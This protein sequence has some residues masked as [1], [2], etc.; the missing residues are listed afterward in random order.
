MGR[1][2]ERW[3]GTAGG[4]AAALLLG[5]GAVM[6]GE[7]DFSAEVSLEPRLFFEQPRYEGQLTDLQLSGVFEAEIEWESE[8]RAWEAILIPW[9]RLDAEDDDRSHV[10]LREG[11]LRWIGDAWEVRAGLGKVFWGVTE[12]RHL[13]DIIN[14][15]DAV[16]DIDEEDKLGQPMVE[17]TTIRNWGTLRAWVL[18]GFRE[19]T[20]PGERG[21]LR[22][23]FTVDKDQAQYESADEERR[24]DGALRYS[25]VFGD[26]D[27]G[28]S[29]FHGT[30]R[31][32]RLGFNPTKQQ[33]FPIYDVI[34][35][36]G[37]DVQYTTGPWLWKFEGIV[38]EGQGETFGAVTGGFEYTF[39]GITETG[40]DLGVLLE[41]HHDGRDPAE[42]PITPFDED[43]FIGARLALN[44]V[45]DTSILVGGIVDAEDGT[46][47]SLIE[48]E[49][50]FGDNWTGEVEGRFFSNVGDDA[51]DPL[52]FSQDD[53]H[54]VLR[55]TRYF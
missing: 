32:P 43:V 12:S 30:S 39:F 21:R 45:Q 1:E 23:P 13:V 8:D 48:A 6:A 5:A 14:Q 36:G 10:D 7:W 55:L 4:A 33:F 29:A 9:A 26:F 11:Y 3:I 19:R 46:T 22:G 35:Q 53:S 16:E 27:V 50:R 38:R 18:P 52:T 2:F 41:Y 44:D 40:A 24:I 15:T 51:N 49:R 54:L 20:F 17:I 37:L 34:T 25:N 42:A 47:S 31:E 28:V